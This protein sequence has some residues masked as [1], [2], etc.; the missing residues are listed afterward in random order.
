MH[1]ELSLVA[2]VC[3]L[4]LS[5]PLVQ[6]VRKKDVST[7]ALLAWLWLLNMIFVIDSIAWAG[8]VDFTP[9]QAGWCDLCTCFRL[10][11]LVVLKNGSDSSLLLATKI[12]TAANIALPACC[13]SI[14]VDLKQSFLSP[15]ARPLP[16]TA[17]SR[18]LIQ[19]LLCLVLPIVYAILGKSMRYHNL[20]D[21]ILIT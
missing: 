15:K 11:P 8:N 10:L 19:A 7:F 4:L 21:I 20:Q 2:G 6:L 18:W 5:I 13:L 12:I 3:V 9:I 1:A 14:C 17:R 16:R